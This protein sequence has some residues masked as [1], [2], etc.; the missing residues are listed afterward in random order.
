MVLENFVDSNAMSK[1]IIY[2]WDIDDNAKSLW[3]DGWKTYKP[4]CGKPDPDLPYLMKI[5]FDKCTPD[6]GFWYKLKSATSL[7]LATI[8]ITLGL[9]LAS[10]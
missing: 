1:P 5:E 2:G 3:A 4:N 10:L 8:A 6:D 9:S 7:K